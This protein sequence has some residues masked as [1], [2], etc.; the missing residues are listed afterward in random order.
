MS[1]KPEMVDEIHSLHEQ[2]EDLTFIKN[3]IQFTFW[4]AL[5]IG[6]VLGAGGLAI[7]QW[8]LS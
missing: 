3:L 4:V 1:L 6:A 2:V 7:V 5:T 8:F